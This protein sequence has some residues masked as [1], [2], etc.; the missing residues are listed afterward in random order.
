MME[1][2]DSQRVAVAKLCE[3]GREF[4][5]LWAEPRSGKTAVALKWLEHLMPKVA[6]VVGPK[7]AEAV[8]KTECAKWLE[9]DYRFFQLTKGNDYPLSSMLCSGLNIMFVNYEQF[10]KSPYKRLGPFLRKLT[11]E[12]NGQGAMILDESHT[13]KTPSSVMGRTIRRLA[14]DWRYRLIITGTPVT[15]PGKVDEVYG[16]WTF[17]DPSI[18]DNWKTAGDFREHFGEWNTAKGWPELIRPRNQA[19]LHRYL[20]TNVVTLTR[21]ETRVTV[22]KLSYQPGQVTRTLHDTMRNESVVEVKGHM[23]VG[24]NPLVRLL[25]MRTIL[26][27]WIKDDEDRVVRISEASADRLA[28]LGSVLDRAGS[29]V[30]VSCT[31]ISEIAQV[32]RWLTRKGIAHEV[33]TGATKDKDRAIQRFQRLKTI[34]VLL[35]QPRTVS[36]AVDLSVASDLVWYT[37]DFNYMTFKQTSDRIKMSLAHPTVWFLCAKGTVDEDV[38]KTL[39]VDH[40]HLRK[41]LQTMG[42]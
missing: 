7:I 23:C 3:P 42:K 18:R 11:K 9:C 22:R 30:V 15:N 27:G 32:K 33:I 5:A 24:L 14:H 6:V 31:H 41:V 35:V 2:R 39:M 10:T 28:T 21:S 1:L 20:G 17:M 38:W 29:K 40:N 13:I 26:A 25:R 4:A 19:E 37:A 12:L 8:W 34:R 16:Q 36:M